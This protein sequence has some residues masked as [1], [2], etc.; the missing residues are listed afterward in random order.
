MQVCQ[1][2]YVCTKYER[3]NKMQFYVADYLVRVRTQ[4]ASKDRQTNI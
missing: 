3:E 2:L 1:L 4:A